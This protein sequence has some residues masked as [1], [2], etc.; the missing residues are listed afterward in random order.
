MSEDQVGAET[1]RAGATALFMR[2]PVLAF[3]LNLL[4]MIAGLAALQGVEIRELP[5]VDQP[6][7]T[8]STTYQGAT[9]ETIDAQVT[10]LIESAVARVQGV[11]SI[12]SQSSYGQSRVTVTFSADTDLNVAASDVRE[13]VAR[14]TRRLPE[15]IDPPT[16]VKADADASPIMQLAVSSQT[17]SV[18][19]VTRLVQDRIVQRLTAVP[20]VADATTY[21]TRAPVIRVAVNQVALASRGL[22]MQDV[23]AALGRAQ[24]DTP[25]GTLE[26]RNQSLLVR[27]EAPVATAAEIA[28]LYI[29]DVTRIG[30]VAAVRAASETPSSIT[31]WNGRLAVGIGILRQA[32]SNTLTISS[33]VHAAVAELRREMPQGTTI[34]VVS[35]DAVF[36]S[37]A[38]TEVVETL[39]IATAIV[40]LVIFLFLTSVRATLIPAITI[41]VCTL[42]TIAGIWLAGFSV[43]IF[44]LFALVLATGMVVDD[45]IVVLENIER[46]RHQGLGLRAAAVLGTREVFF[47]VISTTA[48][49]AAVFVPISFLPGTAGKMFA[50]FGFVLAFAVTISSFVALT[51][52]PV[53][54]ARLPG[55]RKRRSGAPR[56]PALF[57]RG[58]TAVG[59]AAGG[60]YARTLEL[61]LRFRWLAIAGALAFAGFA[62][63]IFLLLPQQLT[64]AEDRSVVIITARANQ[65]VN[66]GYMAEQVAKIED[67][68]QDYV[69]TGEV[70]NVLSFVGRGGTNQAFIV[71]RLAPWSERKRSQ[72]QIQGELQRRFQAVPALRLSMRAPNSLG[73]RGAGTGL[74]FAIT[75]SDYGSMADAAEKL[76]AAMAQSPSFTD[77]ALTYETTQ[78]QLNIRIDRE[79]ATKLG[80]PIDAISTVIRTMVDEYTAAQLFV[81]DRIIDVVLTAGGRP[82]ND[83]SDVENLFI[84]AKDGR[85][86]PLS[87]VVEIKEIA[88]APG[89]GRESQRRAV[90]IRA[91]L[92]EGVAMSQAIA[93]MR[94]LAR[95]TLPAGMGTVLLGE[96]ATLEQSTSGGLVVFAFAIVIVF[97]VLAAQFEN[98][99]SATVI[100]LT[101]PFGL[102]A[103]IYAIVLTGG[104][105]NYYSQIGLVLLVGIIAKN[106]ILVVEFADQLRDQGLSV[107][108]AIR[109]A[110]TIRLR[111]VMMTMISTVIG[112][113]PLVLAFGAGAEAREA[114]G[115]I[116]VGGLGFATIFTLYLIP[117]FYSLLAGFARPRAQEARQLESEL[118]AAAGVMDTRA[119]RA[120][121]EGPQR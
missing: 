5:N 34:A 68:L 31:R 105:I 107:A 93:E 115:W 37:A 23:V 58:W 94:N 27:T 69:R 83:P 47:A 74:N 48:T 70:V 26:N 121:D 85:F 87:S 95:A 36:V 13:A 73:I 67:I 114:L 12:S 17:M 51:L 82:I 30:D 25:S 18:D 62:V 16:V 22:T 101:V 15:K 76:V 63:S 106:G 75:G 96:A 92:A 38:I 19:E 7:V 46:R 55:G 1:R 84:K 57:A 98:L 81:R 59:A 89:L 56:P 4:I 60:F 99:L 113:L 91:A 77:V 10:S 39:F 108:Q 116:V 8:I 117:V 2:R 3:V 119:D 111:P 97:L 79:A 118:V 52:C 53:L 104:S 72:Q 50:E 110:A 14:I 20:G 90:P 66:L 28:A 40:I 32:Q 100:M 35:D 112:G 103:A 11:A 78:P 109:Q 71:A 33:G 42:G 21:G 24:L 49:L 9:P 80:I 65:G 54:A 43:N 41:P 120:A 86:I 6:V 64:P 44:T 29:N 102:A 61:A 45:A 88:V